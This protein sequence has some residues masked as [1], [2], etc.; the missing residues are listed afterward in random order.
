MGLNFD[1]SPYSLDLG[2]M[3]VTSLHLQDENTRNHAVFASKILSEKVFF[4][5]IVSFIFISML[6]IYRL[7]F[8]LLSSSRVK[9]YYS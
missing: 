1:L 5:E 3:L 6:I 2:K 8:M 4:L 7:A 9:I